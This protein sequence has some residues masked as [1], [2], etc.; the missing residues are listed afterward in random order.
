[1][2]DVDDGYLL[3]MKMVEI[4]DVIRFFC[5]WFWKGDGWMMVYVWLV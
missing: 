5:V 4:V 1:M 3:M 2:V